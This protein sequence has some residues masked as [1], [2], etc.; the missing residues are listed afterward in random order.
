MYSDDDFELTYSSQDRLTRADARRAAFKRQ[1]EAKGLNKELAKK[2]E[3]KGKLQ[4]S[5]LKNIVEGQKDEQ[6]KRDQANNKQEKGSKSGTK[7]LRQMEMAQMVTADAK[8]D[9]DKMVKQNEAAQK[10]QE[11]L[12]QTD[13]STEGG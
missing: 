9:A 12:R 11:E 5:V 2:A 3:S 4:L 7:T 10:G 13:V 1:L 8:P 6:T